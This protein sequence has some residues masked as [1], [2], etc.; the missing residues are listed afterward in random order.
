VAEETD[1]EYQSKKSYAATMEDYRLYVAFNDP[2]VR[3]GSALGTDKL[4]IAKEVGDLLMLAIQQMMG[5]QNRGVMMA[6]SLQ[7][8]IQQFGQPV[9][10]T[11]GGYSGAI[12]GSNLMALEMSRMTTQRMQDQFFYA[13]GTAK[14]SARGLNMG[15]VGAVVGDLMSAGTQFSFGNLY[16]RQRLESQQQIDSMRAAATSR[17]DTDMARVLGNAQ[18][19]QDLTMVDDAN[20]AKFEAYT[21]K[22]VKV[23]S[24]LKTIIGSS[25]MG[26]LQAK[27]RETLGVSLPEFGL[28]N[29]D[30]LFSK[31]KA[32]GVTYFG[33]SSLDAL[34]LLNT[35]ADFT[36]QAAA[37]AAGADPRDPATL[38]RFKAFGA[39]TASYGGFA[40]L[41]SATGQTQTSGFMRGQG[42]QMQA[43]DV[44][45][46][47]ANI[48]EDY[49]AIAGQEQVAV[50]TAHYLQV[51]G[52]SLNKGKRDEAQAALKAL[53]GAGSREEIDIA[54]GKLAQVFY[55][56]S[57]G[58]S[59]AG[60]IGGPEGLATKM[61]QLKVDSLSMLSSMSVESQRARGQDA[62]RLEMSRKTGYGL[63]AKGMGQVGSVLANLTGA[64]MGD[65]TNALGDPSRVDA[66]L[67]DEK[68]QAAMKLAGIDTTGLSDRL[69]GTS[70]DN[71]LGI[72]NAVSYTDTAKSFESAGD[73]IEGSQ[74]MLASYISSSKDGAGAVKGDEITEFIA[75]LN[76]EKGV[77]GRALM[78]MAKNS[79][80]KANT[81]ELNEA[82][83]IKD[84]SASFKSLQESEAGAAYLD[85]NGLGNA[86]SFSD[87]IASNP[88]RHLE[89]IQALTKN[90]AFQID[91]KEGTGSK[92]FV[93][94]Y[95]DEKN[96]DAATAMA[97]AAANA[98]TLKAFGASDKDTERKTDETDDQ[99]SKRMGVKHRM[100]IESKLR[101]KD[102]AAGMAR[103]VANE[104]D[105]EF[106][107]KIEMAVKS[108]GGYGGEEIATG[109][110][111]ESKRLK[112][113][114][115]SKKSED[116][117]G[118]TEEEKYLKQIDR[119]TAASERI[120]SN[121]KDEKVAL[122]TVD[123]M[124]V[125][126]LNILPSKQDN[127]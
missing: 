79:G 119:L 46:M 32:G 58:E 70:K 118:K 47:S 14:R 29:A 55:D 97:S 3:A 88:E 67:N 98:R 122:Q 16:K 33:G 99:Y 104:E 51:R 45:E 64:Q 62:M 15:E 94:S 36:A 42:F 43:Y 39:A 26:V 86:K 125:T 4:G 25:D 100:A 113:E 44:N 27:L 41:Q 95:L 53:G 10:N 112:D 115:N 114:M 49:G 30:R 103:A 13:N 54:R 89:V 75:G 108:A 28:E 83:M 61:G 116:K 60:Y 69:K 9:F 63:D 73:R 105:G 78:L 57:G 101:E 126:N 65:L 1:S 20:M 87:Y 82:G 34:A 40:G 71:L 5:I 2:M 8:P 18:V 107:G 120:R 38:A 110:L 92:A 35:Q 117:L 66:V 23:V 121:I 59:Y 80:L 52:A 22:A 90:G 127:K 21:K 56:I 106:A 74:K 77:S 91:P 12:N 72:R 31:A 84:P 11:N 93:M 76:G 7:S 123:N 17:G 50:A 96:A 48:S 109:F 37:T 111:N 24:Q 102:G 19:G 85:R 68:V 6:N 124:N 81:L